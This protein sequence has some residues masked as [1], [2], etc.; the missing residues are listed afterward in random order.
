MD[1]INYANINNPRAKEV[2]LEKMEE[3]NMREHW[4][5]IG[6]TSMSTTWTRGE[7]SARLDYCLT[8]QSLHNRHSHWSSGL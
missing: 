8:S 1:T 4:I 6:P 2:L 7:Q 5:D 3:M